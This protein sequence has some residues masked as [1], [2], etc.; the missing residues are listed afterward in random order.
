[1]KNSQKRTCCDISLIHQDEFHDF[2]KNG[3]PASFTRNRKMPLTDFLFTMINRRG[4][5]LSLELRNY[6][7]TA[8]PGTEISNP[9]Y[10]KQ[11]MKL[12][13][14]AFYELYRHHNRNFYADPGFSTFQGYLV[15]AADGSGVNIPTTKENLEEFGTSRLL[16]G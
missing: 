4:I 16:Y 5:T 10:L 7:K 14:L 12:N 3:K 6:M 11:R 8:H 13:P 2:C 1:M 9:G 15:L